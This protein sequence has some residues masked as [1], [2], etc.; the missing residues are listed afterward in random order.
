MTSNTIIAWEATA[1]DGVQFDSKTTET[2]ERVNDRGGA[3][4]VY[5]V[6]EGQSPIHAAC[7]PENGESLHVFT[8]CGIL[9]ACTDNA[10]QV[11]MPI[12]ELRK[13]GVMVNRVYVHPKFGVVYSSLDLNL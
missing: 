7:I 10:R 8:R 1:V 5:V 12:I 3:R 11:N 6:I 13:N 2:Y 4:S 9:E